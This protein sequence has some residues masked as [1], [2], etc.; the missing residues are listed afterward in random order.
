MIEQQGITKD[1]TAGNATAPA[2]GVGFKFTVTDLATEWN[3]A[4][5]HVPGFTGVIPESTELG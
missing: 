1:S 2:A 4:L 3:N 5:Y